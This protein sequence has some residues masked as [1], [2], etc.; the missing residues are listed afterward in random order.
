MASRLLHFSHG[1]EDFFVTQPSQ[2]NEQ[3]RAHLYPMSSSIK[4]V[5]G[6]ADNGLG[7]ARGAFIG[8]AIELAAGLCIYGIWLLFH[9]AR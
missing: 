1:N 2:E 5:T 6:P 9:A 4:A 7:C 3:E 8:L